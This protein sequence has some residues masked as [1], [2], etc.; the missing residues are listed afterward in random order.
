MLDICWVVFFIFDREKRGR[1]MFIRERV[2]EG[3]YIY[4]FLFIGLFY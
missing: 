2:G 1:K 4:G 3:V